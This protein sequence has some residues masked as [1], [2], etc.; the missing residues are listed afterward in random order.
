MSRI[1]QELRLNEYILVVP[2]GDKL[3]LMY[4]NGLSL[5]SL[6]IENGNIVNH[7]YQYEV[8]NSINDNITFSEEDKVV[9]VQNKTF[10]A[11]SK[12]TTKNDDSKQKKAY[13][14]SVVRFKE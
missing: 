3:Y 5:N 14:V 4:K 7:D 8:T 10:V 11:L 13:S 2:D 6:V 1:K 12:V 9:H